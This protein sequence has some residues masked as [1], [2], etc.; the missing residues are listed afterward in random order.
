[1]HNLESGTIANGPRHIFPGRGGQEGP[2]EQ[3]WWLHRAGGGG[4]LVPHEHCF[5]P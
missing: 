2:A 1:M 3:S 5:C 4:V